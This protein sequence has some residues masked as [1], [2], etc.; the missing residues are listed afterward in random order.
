M[1]NSLLVII[2][3]IWPKIKNPIYQLKVSTQYNNAYYV[4]ENVIKMENSLLV[5][6]D[7]I[8]PKTLYYNTPDF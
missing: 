2:D 3:E 6:F 4:S 7:E 8:W 5:I 1:G